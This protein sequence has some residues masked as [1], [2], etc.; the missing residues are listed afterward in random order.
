MAKPQTKVA[1]HFDLVGH[2]IAPNTLVGGPV[3][4]MAAKLKVSGWMI[5]TADGN[6]KGEA[7]GKE[8]DVEAFRFHL[9][10]LEAD[11]DNPIDRATCAA[12]NPIAAEECCAFAATYRQFYAHIEGDGYEDMSAPAPRNAPVPS[13]AHPGDNQ[14]TMG[15]FDRHGN[16]FNTTLY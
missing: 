3:E 9:E 7:Q 8:R 6:W 15:R 13:V 12:N 5:N 11:E 10:A 2:N 4:R 16:P 1:M 14:M